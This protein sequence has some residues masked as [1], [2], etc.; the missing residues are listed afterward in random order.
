MIYFKH[1]SLKKKKSWAFILFQTVTFQI[2]SIVNEL[3]FSTLK[4]TVS[5]LIKVLLAPIAH[6]HVD[7]LLSS[8]IIRTTR[9]KK[10]ASVHPGPA[11][12]CVNISIQY[13]RC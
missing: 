11:A 4:T 6:V 12:L 7:A 10:M 13:R 9:Q 8:Y 5:P 2:K 3:I 1:C